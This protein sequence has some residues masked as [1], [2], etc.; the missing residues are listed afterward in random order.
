MKKAIELLDLYNIER[1]GNYYWKKDENYIGTDINLI[2]NVGLLNGSKLLLPIYL[3]QL[4][5]HMSFNIRDA[6]IS[7]RIG[8]NYTSINIMVFDELL[9]IITMAKIFNIMNSFYVANQHLTDN[10]TLEVLNNIKVMNRFDDYKNIKGF[11]NVYTDMKEIILDEEK[12]KDSYNDANKLFI[13]QNAFVFYQCRYKLDYFNRTEIE[14]KL[15]DIEFNLENMRK[16]RILIEMD[17][18][19]ESLIIKEL[20][21][22]TE[23][24]ILKTEINKYNGKYYLEFK[25]NNIDEIKNALNLYRTH[26]NEIIMEEYSNELYSFLQANFNVMINNHM[27]DIKYTITG[28]LTDTEVFEKDDFNRVLTYSVSEL[29]ELLINK[30]INKI[31]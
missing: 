7:Y 2:F 28:F 22:S 15:N 6:R 18:L 19:Y 24:V 1:E 21:H 26:I 14:F 5:N 4:V 12:I 11:E 30:L 13:E 23:L 17:D 8:L 25:N 31:V 20:L 10:V 9:K 27:R 3:E 29:K 16:N